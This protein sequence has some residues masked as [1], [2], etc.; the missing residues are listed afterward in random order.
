MQR[1]ISTKSSISRLKRR[2]LFSSSLIFA[3]KG[4]RGGEGVYHTID[5]NCAFLIFHGETKEK[6]PLW[7]KLLA[8]LLNLCLAGFFC[9]VQEKFLASYPARQAASIDLDSTV[10]AVAAFY[11]CARKLKVGC[12]CVL[13]FSPPPPPSLPPQPILRLYRY[14]EVPRLFLLV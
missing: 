5:S 2:F 14:M 10:Y 13:L 6:S 9:I 3:S 11:L 7:E 4:L 12:L 8:V 1:G